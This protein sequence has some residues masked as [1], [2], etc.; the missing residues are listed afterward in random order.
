MKNGFEIRT[1]GEVCEFKYGDSLPERKRI[2]GSIPVYGSN[3]IVGYH[4]H[5][6]THGETIIIG[7]KGS[8][9]EVHYSGGPCFPIDT[10]YYISETKRDCHLKWLY[11][12]LRSLRLTELNKS[13]AVP[14]LNRNDAYEK[15]ILFPPPSIQKQI[16]A[17]LEKADAAREKRRHANRLTEQFLQSSF[18]EMFGDPVTNPKGWEKRRVDEYADIAYGYSIAIDNSLTAADGYPMIRMANVSLEGRLSLDDLCYVALSEKQFAKFKLQKGDL[19]LNWRNGSAEHVGK[20]VLFDAE[21]DFVCASFLLRVRANRSMAVPIHLWL[22]LNYLR[23]SGYFLSLIRHQINSKFNATELAAMRFPVPPLTDQ[24]KFAALV[25]KVES[26]RAKQ[27][28]SE[29]E[30]E[31]LFNSLMQRAFRGELVR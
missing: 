30:L 2:S 13:S 28:K 29:K 16:A 12:V 4:N 24:Q 3:G 26:L 14:G 27:R 17:I 31:E 19:L 22:M 5:S 9:G 20:T 21:G 6:V 7:R 11:Y 10:T 25:E 1:L 23:K 18:L 8:I 15:K